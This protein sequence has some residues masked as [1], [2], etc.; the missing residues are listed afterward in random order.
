MAFNCFARPLVEDFLDQCARAP[1]LQAER[2]ATEVRLFDT[3]VQRD[4]ECIAEFAQ[5]I[6]GIPRAGMRI[7]EKISHD[8][9]QFIET[10]PQAG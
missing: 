6:R 5:W 3:V 1:G 4:V 10:V 2:I 8:V 9:L 7:A